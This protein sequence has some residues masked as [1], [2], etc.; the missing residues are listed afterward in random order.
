ME[1]ENFKFLSQLVS[2][3]VVCVCVPVSVW[4]FVS[5]ISVSGNQKR[6]SDLMKLQLHKVVSLPLW[7]LETKSQSF[8]RVVG[9][10]S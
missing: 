1:K 8:A 6:A 7:V 9:A 4:G 2:L 5:D 3:K 10:L